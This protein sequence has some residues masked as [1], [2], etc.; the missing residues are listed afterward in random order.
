MRTTLQVAVLVVLAW[1]VIH[2]DTTEAPTAKAYQAYQDG[3]YAQCV[4]FYRAAI[5]AGASHWN[6]F[7]NAACCYALDGQT[8]SAFTY[9]SRAIDQGY[10]ETDWLKADSDFKSLHA[11]PRWGG[12]VARVET[13]QSAYLNSINIELYQ[14][15]QADQADRQSDLIDWS[16]VNLRDTQRR[17]RVQTMLDSG[18]VAT[19]DDYFHAA[20]V[21]QH[22]NDSSD[23]S[24]AHKL[25]TTAVELDA[26]HGTAKWLLAA[27][28]DRYLQSIG[29][30]QWY[31]TQS[32]MIDGRWTIEPIDTTAV[33]DQDRRRLGVPSLAEARKRAEERNR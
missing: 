6:L 22:G 31:G 26:T 25:A 15:Y 2:A 24:L 17:L 27:T 28:K 14:I 12:I 8:D 18:L 33:T 9:L 30:P 1:T 3:E 13:A 16:E 21:F 23:Y 20:M 29:K 4:N 10:R 11:D 7:Y 32:R 19:A 5:D